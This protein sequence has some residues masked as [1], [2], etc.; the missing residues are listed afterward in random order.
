VIVY[1]DP[2]PGPPPIDR[3]L[4]VAAGAAAASALRRAGARQVLAADDRL[5]HGPSSAV[6][7]RHVRL[8]RAWAREGAGGDRRGV[9]DLAATLELL[10]PELPVVLW[11]SDAW[12]ELLALFQ[13]LHSVRRARLAPGRLLLAS[14]PGPAAVG[15]RGSREL[16]RVLARAR[17]L[18]PAQARAGAALWRAFTAPTPAAL[19]RARAAGARAFPAF[20][21]GV[22]QH[23]A[24]FP[25]SGGRA[26]RALRLSELD[27]VLLGGL[28]RFWWRGAREAVR[29]SGRAG[30]ALAAAHGDALVSRRLLDWAAARPD[31]A[32]EYRVRPRAG[33]ARIQFRITEAGRRLRAG[34][35]DALRRAPPLP[36]GGQV[37]YRGR[38]AWICVKT[39]AGWR[40]APRRSR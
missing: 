34:D 3:A 1:R 21:Q 29:A 9:A 18:E 14:A 23:A 30:R 6:A 22:A 37:A 4:H 20:A 11:T 31:P 24:L 12:R 8:R 15:E 25:R 36:A 40:L 33:D 13:A 26:S 5:S 7:H 19:Q 27:E 32:V 10:P 28:S 35:L 39:P 17:P 16:V 38:P 2:V